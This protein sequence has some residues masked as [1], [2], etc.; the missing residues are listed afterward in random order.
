MSKTVAE[1][2]A[3]LRSANADEFAVLKR[4][5]VADT[6]KGVIA[7]VARAER[8]LDEQAA[9]EAR[10][11][12]LYAF[13]ESLAHEKGA[14]VIVG[15]DE[16][17]RGSIAGPLAVGAVVLNRDVRIAGLND[18]KQL[19]PEQRERIAREIRETAQAYA[20]AYIEPDVIDAVGMTASL[21]KAFRAA[22]A[23]IEE[24]GVKPDIVLLDGNPLHFDE[25]EVNVIKGDA[26]CASISAASVVAK[27]ERDA[28]MVRL[29]SE[30]PAYHWDE[31]KG[32]A[33]AAHIEAIKEC[34]LSPYHRVSFCTAF[35]QETLF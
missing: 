1:I 13:E 3:L 2:E 15:L 5:L 12:G 30:Y 20:V 6:R 25:R 16:V 33:S 9:E 29:S 18:S 26:K 22:L 28:L 35:T 34:G 14:Q 32:Y 8:R 31:C 27:V 7:A 10:L 4:S 17:G 11:N 24:Q 21:I 19:K 23:S